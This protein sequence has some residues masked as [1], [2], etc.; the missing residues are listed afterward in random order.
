VSLSNRLGSGSVHLLELSEGVVEVVEK[1]L[2]E[3]L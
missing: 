1:V 2:L 3:F